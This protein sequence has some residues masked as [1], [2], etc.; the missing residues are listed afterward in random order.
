MRSKEGEP[1]EPASELILA[2]FNEINQA[3][4]S[5]I[6]QWRLGQKEIIDKVN[7]NGTHDVV[8]DVDIA[9]ENITNETF[10]GTVPVFGEES[11]RSDLS[12][13]EESLYIVVDPIDGTKEF[14]KGSDEWSISLCAVQNGVPIVASIFMPDKRQHFTAVRG[15][16]LKLN[17]SILQPSD[18]AR[19]SI[20]VSPR[21]IK[22]PK[23]IEHITRTGLN[24]L[25]ISA[26]TPKICALLRGEVHSAVYFPQQGQSA[27]LW[28]YAAGVLLIQESGGKITSLCG[29]ELPFRGNGII[30]KK[31]WLAT[32]NLDH[33]HLLAC[34]GEVANL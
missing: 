6:N 29:S 10:S 14:V 21:Q 33:A 13:L 3:A 31:G 22:D 9:I 26:L 20:A 15:K 12:L 7:V 5:V 2:S 8:T 32:R 17:G 19:R 16:G 23:I 28:D 4:T 1:T 25:E 24:P 30:H 27:S 18:S 11:F 34:L